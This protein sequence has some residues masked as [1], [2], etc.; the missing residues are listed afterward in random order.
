MKKVVITGA[1]GFIGK[2]LT[3][4]FMEN[5]YEVYALVHNTVPEEIKNCNVIKV[6]LEHIEKAEKAIPVGID[7]FYHL[8]WEG[9]NSTVKDDY[10]IQKKNIDY[11]LSVLK[12]AEKLESKKV[13]FTGSVSEYAYEDGAVNGNNVPSPSDMYSACKVSTHYICDLYS[14]KNNINFIWTLIPSIYGPGRNDSNIITYSIKSFLNKEKP[15]FTK[16]EQKWDYIYIDDL[17]RGLYLIGKNGLGNNTYTLG[18]GKVNTL[19]YYIEKIRDSI[20]KTLPMGIGELPYKTSKI[21]NSIVDI[22]LTTKDTGY[23]PKFTF[24]EGIEKTIEY[25]KNL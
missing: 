23:V 4:Y 2:N 25:F 17:I 18:S 22:S 13:I 6:D 1:N 12:L 16:L 3:K 7:I 10:S 20:D 11:S 19:A 8:A 21:D 9:V 15:S 5:N 14:R 24:E